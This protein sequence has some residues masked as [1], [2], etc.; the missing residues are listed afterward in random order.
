MLPFVLGSLVLLGAC[1]DPEPREDGRFICSDETPCLIGEVCVDGYCEPD[2]SWSGAIDG[3]PWEP[4]DDGVDRSDIRDA[5][6]PDRSIGSDAEPED[7]FVSPG[8]DSGRPDDQGVQDMDAPPPDTG[9]DLDAQAQD[10]DTVDSYVD[11][12]QPDAIVDSAI[13][14]ILDADTPDALLP[15]MDLP[16]P[17][18]CV[19]GDET[20]QNGFRLFYGRVQETELYRRWRPVTAPI[21]RTGLCPHTFFPLNPFFWANDMGPL[22]CQASDAEIRQ[23]ERDE[24]GDVVWIAEPL[25]PLQVLAFDMAIDHRVPTAFQEDQ[26]PECRIPTAIVGAY[27][28]DQLVA[29]GE[30]LTVWF[31]PAMREGGPVDVRLRLF[32]PGGFEPALSEVIGPVPNLPDAMRLWVMMMLTSTERGEVNLM[33]WAQLNRQGNLSPLQAWEV[34]GWFGDLP[35]G[36]PDTVREGIRV[37]H[38]FLGRTDGAATSPFVMCH[39][40]GID[41]VFAQSCEPTSGYSLNVMGQ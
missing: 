13:D 18:P 33:I 27:D 20:A 35:L 38:A 7:V 40:D 41:H 24:R 34:E 6:P 10:A 5:Q 9:V 26:V 36:V 29:P 8:Q 11:D 32:R 28:R 25:P 16:V 1:V 39:A 3:Q 21:R 14:A 23:W 19:L 17:E 31:D 22:A 2:P 4:F 30:L 15:D 37:T 12:A